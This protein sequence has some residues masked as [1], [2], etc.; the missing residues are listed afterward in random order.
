MLPFSEQLP[1]PLVLIFAFAAFLTVKLVGYAGACAVLRKAFPDTTTGIWKAA[2]IRVCLGVAGGLMYVAVW[3]L[4]PIPERPGGWMTIL[5]HLGLFAVRMGSWWALY[6]F[7]FPGALREAKRG[8][9]CAMVGALWSHAL[10]FPAWI[11]LGLTYGWLVW[12]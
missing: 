7:A 8:F 9:V 6:H 4:I 3:S 1:E 10:D 11:A 12:W 5:Y 2:S